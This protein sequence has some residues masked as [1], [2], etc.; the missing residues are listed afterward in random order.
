MP[1]LLTE[2]VILRLEEAK[3][4]K[5][6]NNRR[7]VER[8][9]AQHC[10]KT[11]RNK[12]R[13][14]KEKT[15]GPHLEEG[16]QFMTKIVAR[17]VFGHIEHP[18]DGRSDLNKAAILVTEAWMEGDEVFINFETLST[19]PGRTIASLI[20]DRLN[21]GLSSRATGSIVKMEDGVDEVQEDFEP[22][23][24]DCVADPSV[25]DAR[26]TEEVTKRLTEAYEQALAEQAS[27]ESAKESAEETSK[28]GPKTG[29]QLLMERRQELKGL[30]EFFVSTT[31]KYKDAWVESGMA[32]IETG[33]TG[34]LKYLAADGDDI[35]DLKA[36]AR[37]LKPSARKLHALLRK[38]KMER[39]Q[40]DPDFAEHLD[41]LTGIIEFLDPDEMDWDEFV[42]GTIDQWESIVNAWDVW[43]NLGELSETEKSAGTSRVEELDEAKGNVHIYTFKTIRGAEKAW[44]IVS[45]W[46]GAFDEVD[47]V[48]LDGKELYIAMD[49][50]AM[51]P[52]RTYDELLNKVLVRYNGILD[53]LESK[54]KPEGDKLDEAPRKGQRHMVK[55]LPDELDFVENDYPIDLWKNEVWWDKNKG[56]VTMEF[57]DKD[58]AVAIEYAINK[59]RPTLKTSVRPIASQG[60]YRLKVWG[61]KYW[62]EGVMPKNLKEATAVSDVVLFVVGKHD[63]QA[64]GVS[65]VEELAEKLEDLLGDEVMVLKDLMLNDSLIGV[66][67]GSIRD[68]RREYTKVGARLR[69]AEVTD[70]LKAQL[71]E[72]SLMKN[73]ILINFDERD[74]R[75]FG[76]DDLE[77]LEG[78]FTDSDL[79]PFVYTDTDSETETVL[80][81]DGRDLRQ[82]KAMFQSVGAKLRES[83]D[84][85]LKEK[86]VKAFMEKKKSLP[87]YSAFA[88]EQYDKMSLADEELGKL[89]TT[90]HGPSSG[91]MEI[92]A[93]MRPDLA[94][95][96]RK[97]KKE[98]MK[99]YKKVPKEQQGMEPWE[100]YLQNALKYQT[101][102]QHRNISER[103]IGIAATDR[104]AAQ[105]VLE[106][107]F[108]YLDFLWGNSIKPA[109]YIIDVVG[110]DEDFQEVMDALKAKRLRVWRESLE[111][112]P[113]ESAE[114][115]PVT[116]DKPALSQVQIDEAA[117]KLI[118]RLTARNE[119]L[120]KALDEAQEK[121]GVLEEMNQTMDDL[122]RLKE[123]SAEQDR[124]VI[125][126][127]VLDRAQHIL[128]KAQTVDELRRSAREL[129]YLLKES[130]TEPPPVEESQE[131]EV[132]KEPT[133][134]I[135]ETSSGATAKVSSDDKDLTEET[136]DPL[137]GLARRH[138]TKR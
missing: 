54:Q 43:L 21:F 36:S 137:A 90:M 77:E 31:G 88:K 97:C 96:V 87:D 80:A 98:A 78:V 23:T 58:T 100:L 121:I 33:N 79:Y 74:F 72:A 12:R 57:D 13:Y 128:S 6:E 120:Q 112:T 71:S 107:E 14:M 105:K 123:L 41:A 49:P 35:S 75:D 108:P 44:D 109:S 66:F 22:E 82:V 61:G 131:E 64:F 69:E 93:G 51:P 50:K 92:A 53:R 20:D 25:G 110:D 135:M 32:D 26:V 89:A 18:E 60:I 76:V 34:D 129:L 68:L 39:E 117:Q 42:T 102:A 103:L 95:E 116:E 29:K 67:K 130:P 17:Q 5:L 84:K 83:T 114:P 122:V 118:D 24:W 1:Q 91:K 56:E 11:N 126:F 127:P 3:I 65:D 111:D 136:Y 7:R 27:E 15:W 104:A 94:A 19:I 37:Q 52:T 16:S 132:D 73:M 10:N 8:V 101:E 59:K 99:A 4:T 124:L 55:S 115:E 125:K 9:K 113:Q 30:K 86:V 133:S 2:R 45:E 46:V 70:E 48:Q 63:Y 138:R 134:V 106:R 38:K 62:M 119:E 40:I 47:R 85:D 81:F 28:A